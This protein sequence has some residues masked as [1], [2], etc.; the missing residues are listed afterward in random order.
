MSVREKIDMTR[1]RIGIIGGGLTGLT[2]AYRLIQNGV[3]VTIFEASGD[4]GGLASGF[5]LAGHPVEKAYHFLYKTD[6][7]ILA[8]VEQLG[9]SNRLAYNPSSVSTSYWWHPVSDD[10]AD[11]PYQVHANQ[12]HQ[13]HPR[14]GHCAL[15]AAI[16]KLAHAQRDH[17]ARMAAAL[18]RARG[19]RRHLGAAAARQIRPLLRQ[20]DDVVAVGEGEAAR[21]QPR[22]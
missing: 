18:G 9:L 4:L 5:T 22:C 3:D 11:R 7:Y 15:P 8:L 14:R 2:A 1:P 13:P 17:G 6:E 20:G 19:H 16:A 10:D 21:R 12:L